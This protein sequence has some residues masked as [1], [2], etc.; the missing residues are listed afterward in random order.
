MPTRP[1]APVAAAPA[2]GNG[3]VRGKVTGETG[4]PIA[5]A[6]VAVRS[7]RDS[8][9]VTGAMT[10][11][12]GRFRVPGLAPGRYLLRISQLG[13]K[14][15]TLAPLT[16]SAT[17]P[18]ADV[19]AVKLETAPVELQGLEV[20]AAPQSVVMTAD[21]TIYRTKDMPVASTGKAVDV[22]RGIP[23]LEVDV[24]GKVTMR[25]NA[26]VAIHLNDRPAPMRGEA[27]QTWL[28][29]LP[30]NV[31]ERVEVIPNPSAKYDPEGLGGIL[32]IVL[33]SN[34]DLG[35]S[36]TLTGNA[37]TRGQ[38]GISTRLAYQKGR[39]TFF[40]GGGLNFYSMSYN[41]HDLREN[42]L[43]RPVTYMD[44]TTASSTSARFGMVDATTEYKVDK[45]TTG[46]LSLN[47]YPVGSG[48]DGT[49][50]Y[51]ILDSL[52][53]ATQRY[54]RLTN[55][56]ASQWS[57]NFALGLRRQI[58]PQRHEWSFEVRSNGRGGDAD[59]HWNQQPL[60]L[61]GDSVDLPSLTLSSQGQHFREWVAQ[62]DYTHPLGARARADVGVQG[63]RR[64]DKADNLMQFF[65][66][67][68]V[69]LSLTE[70]TTGYEQHEDL[71]S[72]YLNVS[73]PMKKLQLQ[74]GLRGERA[75][76]SFDVTRTGASY[77]NAYT[78]LFPSGSAL[79]DLGGGKRVR[80]SYSKRLDRPYSYYL[81]PD[82]PVTDPLNRYAGNPYLKP[83][84]THS[85]SA[86]L[87]LARSELTWRLAPYFR[88]TVNDWDNLKSVDSL[89]VSTVTWANIRSVN[90]YGAS[91]TVS[92]RQTKRLG[93]FLSASGYS[94]IYN[95]PDLSS[96]YSRRHFY[97]SLNGNASLKVTSSLDGQ[98]MV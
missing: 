37:S 21:R 98:T 96:A 90:T 86:E 15:Q 8:S 89:G 66:P 51:I 60:T 97:V 47:G 69:V 67:G 83:R 1:Q 56:D 72:A 70:S 41:M 36:G 76:T 93:G 95:A 63:T 59:S 31:I 25:G 9:L 40:G 94:M 7:A 38:T 54:A 13:Y 82:V 73:V 4:Q 5:A 68:V 49:L 33:K 16:L 92:L 62:A 34:V 52:Q 55:T 46:W 58:V 17:S 32:N 45:K 20:K 24:N 26:S 19:G 27:L 3:S 87:S 14:P 11:A 23:E 84:Y 35:L 79:Y 53:Q 18:D 77:P 80:L 88:R 85:L 74:G 78:S 71:A 30:G 61:A 10:G 91:A 65:A 12:D 81:N 43:T 2:A 64:R 44:L 75:R 57:A 42:L 28:Q 39:L 29:Q 48:S 50:G 22:L 6:S